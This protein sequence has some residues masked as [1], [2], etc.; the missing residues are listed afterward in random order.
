MEI[1]FLGYNNKETKLINFLEK[2]GHSVVH[3]KEEIDDF[4][5]FDLVISFGYKFIVKKTYLETLKRPILNLHISYLPFNKG[6]HPNFWSH[7]NNTPSGVSIHEIFENREYRIS[8]W[9][10]V[11][12]LTTKANRI[13]CKVTESTKT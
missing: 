11:T 7:F 8:S 2:S 1:L 3:S 5:S 13:T 10:N 6:A 4:S 9:C 12:H